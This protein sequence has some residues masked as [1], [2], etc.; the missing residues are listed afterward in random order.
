MIAM[1]VVVGLSGAVAAHRYIERPRV[2]SPLLWESWLFTI[3]IYQRGI[4]QTDPDDFGPPKETDAPLLARFCDEVKRW[5]LPK[6]CPNTNDYD[7]WCASFKEYPRG[8]PFVSRAFGFLACIEEHDC[9][10]GGCSKYWDTYLSEDGG[11]RFRIAGFLGNS[12]VHS[13]SALILMLALRHARTILMHRRQGKG[14]GFPVT[15]V[16]PTDPLP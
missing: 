16:E 11:P 1:A 3:Y 9:K 8:W 12:A 4:V 10:T 14:A 7:L 6:K 13:A 5:G 15:I 2:H